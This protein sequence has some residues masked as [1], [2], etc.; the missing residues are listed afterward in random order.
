[1]NWIADNSRLSRTENLKSEHV[2]SN[3]PLHIGTP[4]TTTLSRLP[5]DRRRRDSGKAGSYA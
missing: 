3:R 1:V 5:V 2:Q 4:D